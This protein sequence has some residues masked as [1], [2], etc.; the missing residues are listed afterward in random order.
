MAG[1]IEITIAKKLNNGFRPVHLEV[2]NESH[3]HNVPEN[4]ET[5]FKVLMVS[6]SFSGQSR[7]ARQRQ[8]YQT[9]SIEL[10]GPVH[11]LS[12]RLLTPDEWEASGEAAAPD[13]PHCYGGSQRE[14][15][16]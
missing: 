10:E 11:A 2:L 9:L 12:L 5:H 7:V 15:N 4:S 8:V 6:E 16:Q 1:L 3:S 13:S 14:E